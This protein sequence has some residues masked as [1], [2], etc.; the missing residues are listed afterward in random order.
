MSSFIGPA[1]ADVAASDILII[2]TGINGGSGSMDATPKA[3]EIG[4]R[5]V[6][7]ANIYAPNGT[8]LIKQG[9]TAT[10]AFW[11]QWVVIGEQVRLTR[12]SAID[13]TPPD[14]TASVNPP[15]NATGWHHQDVTVTFICADAGSGIS[16]CPEPIVVVDEGAGRIV[17]G[18]A[19]DRAGNSASVSVTVNHDK[20]PPAVSVISPP[21]G[22]VR[23]SSPAL[24]TGTSTDA[25]SGV[26]GVSCGG[27]IAA[28][29]ESTFSCQWSLIEGVNRVVAQAADQAGN[30]GSSTLTVTLD[31]ISPVVSILSPADGSRVAVDGVAVSGLVDDPTATVVVDGLVVPVAADGSWS[32]GSLPLN[33]GDNVIQAVAADQAGNHGQGQVTIY[34]EPMAPVLILCARPFQEEIPQPPIAGCDAQSTASYVGYG[35]TEG[36]V[37]GTIDQRSTSLTVNGVLLPDGEEVLDTGPVID[38][39]RD[40]TFFWAYIDIPQTP[41]SYP[42]TAVATDAQDR[43]QTVTVSLSPALIFCAERFVEQ[44]P[45]APVESC[46]NQAIGKTTGFVSGM[47]DESEVSVSI[48]GVLLPDGVEI[49]D[50]G[51]ISDGMREGTFFWAF[52]NI[53]QVDGL[54]PF[55]AAATNA[56]GEERQT[57]VS[58][59]RD[60]VPPH[61]VVTAPPIGT[62]VNAQSVVITGTVDDPDA[63][64][65][66]G[67]FG[68]TIPVNNGTFQ[69]NAALPAEGANSILISAGDPSGNSSSVSIQVIRDTIPPMVTVTAPSSGDA[70]NTPTIAVKGAVTDQNPVTASILVNGSPPQ[71]VALSAGTYDQAITLQNGS[72]TLLLEAV[73]AAGN[74]GTASRTIVVDTVPPLVKITSPPAGA[75][76]TGVVSVTAEVSDLLSGVAHVELLANGVSVAGRSTEPYSFSVNTALLPAGSTTL[77]V[78]AVDHVSNS[79]EAAIQIDILGGQYAIR[80]TSP[81]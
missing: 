46:A 76:L 63:I 56:R 66:L 11:G 58:F 69:V 48:N 74:K 35:T 30:V 15:P 5:N 60:T 17:T 80:I 73:D 19:I 16:R 75:Q 62:F 78:H 39:M 14:I 24:I 79:A 7:N 41:G 42:V 25:L 52:V 72:N 13:D 38:A 51:A 34:R 49:M 53:P 47:I 57:T 36:L 32:L 67:F 50:D 68:Q 37:V 55:T 22:T 71:P 1:A 8:L 81:A 77:T 23:N 70:V 59:L 29:S 21:D 12:A 2:A 65:R 33:E 61:P 20:T 6:I 40:G 27:L 3:I 64:V 26:A 31:T 28:L 10:G 54:H 44:T 43:A 4:M 45:Q 9:S 18:T